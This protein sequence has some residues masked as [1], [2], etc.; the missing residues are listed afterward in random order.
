[1]LDVAAVSVLEPDSFLCLECFAKHPMRQDTVAHGGKEDFLRQLQKV[2][3]RE[4]LASNKGSSQSFASVLE[5]APGVFLTLVRKRPA[6][7]RSL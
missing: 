7:F 3:L 2:V 1:M 4:T 5:L 6:L